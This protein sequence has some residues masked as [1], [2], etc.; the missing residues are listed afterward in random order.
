MPRRAALLWSLGCLIA[1]AV[2][3]PTPVRAQEPAVDDGVAAPVAGRPP[4]S[5]A[6]PGSPPH[7]LPRDMWVHLHW[8]PFDEARLQSLLHASRAELW[9]WLRDD[10]QTLAQLGAQ[11]GHP[12]PHELAAALVAPRAAD[13]SAA[14]LRRLRARTLRVLVQGH[15]SQHLIFHSLHQEA[16]PEAAADLFGVR[17]TA[18]FQRERRLDL[19]PLRIGRAHGRTRARMQGGLE[20]ELRAAARAGVAGG[21]T[22][23]RQAAIVLARQLRQVPRWLGEDHYNGPPQTDG[24]ALRYPFRPSFAS[25]ALASDGGS[26]LFDAQ[27]PAPPLAVR[28]G[29]L[30]LEGRELAGGTQIDPRDG[31]LQALLDRPCSSYGPSLSSD[32]RRIA[33]EISAGNR[34]YAKRYGNVVVAVADLGTQTVRVVAGGTHGRRV[35]TAYDPVLSSDGAVV[36]YERV[37]ADPMSP[38]TG[39]S[40]RVRVLDLRTG[41]AF[42]VPRAGAYEPTISGDGRHVAF[43]AFSH[44]RLHVFAADRRTRQVTLVSRIGRR[45]DR[46]AEAWDP[47]ISDD[48]R[49]VAFAATTRAGGRARVYVRELRR[50]AARAVSGPD[51]GF[52]SEP[53]LSADGQRVAYSELAGA[54]RRSPAG[55]PLQRVVVRNLAGG[56]LRIVSSDG[57]G[58]TLAG[59]SGQ[60]QIS[61]DGTRVAFTTD[62]GTAAGG[63]PGGLRVLVRD[64]AAGTTTVVSPA[65][66]L[67]A[68]Q[69]GPG[70][71]QPAPGPLCSLAPPAW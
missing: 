13:V 49:R 68:F 50:A 11:R 69:T 30:V 18:A 61:A 14:M 55:R 60:P 64:V 16:G 63:G 67:G 40:T 47:S 39:A 42:V 65:A 58:Q 5:D 29:E 51:A 15:L 7:W 57:G 45:R 31:S 2:A 22:S 33:Y 54:G 12:S 34:T 25:P 9:R 70:A 66:P 52:A 36:A 26:V 62:A 27:Q 71:L 6:P 19:S 56:R 20:R 3:G 38:S 46:A 41:A 1:L 43:S 4:D 35:E 28:Y 8:V 24:G 21:D 53:T 44:G 17:D 23:P 48:G 59:W 32:G 10:T 37:V